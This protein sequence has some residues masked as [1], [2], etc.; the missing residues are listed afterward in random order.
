M[1]SGMFEEGERAFAMSYDSDGVNRLYEFG[2]S[3]GFDEWSGGIRKQ[4]WQYAT[5]SYNWVDPQS[6]N[7]FLVKKL[8]RAAVIASEIH[9]T[10]TCK[11]YYRGYAE[12]FF[13]EY[14][15]EQ[16]AGVSSGNDF[17]W[18][19]A[20][21]FRFGEPDEQCGRWEN[22]TTGSTEFQFLITGTGV[23]QIERAKFA[24]VTPGET[25]AETTTCDEELIQT[26]GDVTSPPMGDFDYLIA[27]S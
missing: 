27:I 22:S 6:S 20:V 25:T 9:G 21:I 7:S 4:E 19:G 8:G 2:K 18:N 11:L 23:V 24:F 14:D 3:D 17:A 12:P 16:N 13:I 5:K 26:S 1:V 15:E 10:A